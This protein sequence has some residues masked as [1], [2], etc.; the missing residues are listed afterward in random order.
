MYD[1]MVILHH[2]RVFTQFY[3]KN[4]FVDFY[5]YYDFSFYYKARLMST[6]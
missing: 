2:W 4:G 1:Y 3:L 5:I 6:L